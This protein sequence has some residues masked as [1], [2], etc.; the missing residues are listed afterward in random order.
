MGA[1]KFKNSGRFPWFF[2][3]QMVKGDCYWGKTYMTHK[4]LEIHSLLT[5]QWEGNLG[6]VNHEKQGEV[7]PLKNMICFNDALNRF[8]ARRS[9]RREVGFG[10][11]S[12]CD[13]KEKARVR[14]EDEKA[15]MQRER[16]RAQRIW[17]MLEQMKLSWR[18]RRWYDGDSDIDDDCDDNGILM[19]TIIIM[20]VMLTVSTMM[21]MITMVM[22]V[23]KTAEIC[24][25]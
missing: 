8:L 1:S 9:K 2:D 24:S 21:I 5:K 19:I 10:R 13:N 16:R 20:M 4:W 14:N 3:K 12:V 18:W 15:V 22:T 17:I 11:R 6:N 7:K 25:W 23:I